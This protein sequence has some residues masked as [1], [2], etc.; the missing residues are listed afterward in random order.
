MKKSEFLNSPCVDMCDLGD[1]SVRVYGERPGEVVLSALYPDGVVETVETGDLYEVSGKCRAL[2]VVGPKAAGCWLDERRAEI[3]AERASAAE[4]AKGEP[5]SDEDMNSLLLPWAQVKGNVVTRDMV[6]LMADAYKGKN[7]MAYKIACDA[8]E[9]SDA[10]WFLMGHAKG[11]W[12]E[13][14]SLLPLSSVSDAKSSGVREYRIPVMPEHYRNKGLSRVVG[15][16][17][18]YEEL[19]AEWKFMLNTIFSSREKPTLK[20][21]FLLTTDVY[22]GD[23]LV[24]KIPVADFGE[25]VKAVERSGGGEVTFDVVWNDPWNETSEPSGF[26]FSVT[27]KKII[28]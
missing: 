11:D 15:H 17:F 14:E 21:P 12:G 7:G 13:P 24:G 20:Y 28:T 5:C 16:K 4:A 2:K 1:H 10:K 25:Y 23:E 19:Y 6:K 27:E 9:G 8:L 18:T 22:Y 3:E 26:G